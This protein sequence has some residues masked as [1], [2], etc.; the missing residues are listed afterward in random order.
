MIERNK[1]SAK[2]HVRN[3]VRHYV[4]KHKANMTFKPTKGHQL[5]DIRETIYKKMPNWTHVTKQ[6]KT[7]K[8][9]NLVNH[10]K[11]LA[12]GITTFA[13]LESKQN[14]EKDFTPAHGDWVGYVASQI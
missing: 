12:D 5:K 6:N 9:K 3:K 4:R 1:K 10:E 7:A 11:M 8:E 2:N 13:G 14:K